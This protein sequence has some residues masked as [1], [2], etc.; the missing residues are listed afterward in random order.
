M[1]P[2]PV[3]DRDQRPQGGRFPGSGR[4]VFGQGSA[5]ALSMKWSALHEAAEAVAA[6][7]GLEVQA[8]TP[9][10]R[11]FPIVA[12]DAGG[13]LYELAQQAVADLS[14]MMEPG[15]AA[16]LAAHARGANPGPAAQALWHEFVRARDALMQLVPD[17]PPN[18]T[19]RST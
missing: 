18:S 8:M 10:V 17:T 5:S 14:A 12:R 15:L 3:T 16:L 9:K 4:P 19:L 11:N 1:E 13:P 6:I 2:R 7:A